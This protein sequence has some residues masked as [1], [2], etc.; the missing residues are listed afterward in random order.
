MGGRGVDPSHRVAVKGHPWWR[1]AA[2]Y[3]IYIRSFA[4]GDGD[5]LGDISGMRA[6]LGY[7]RDLGV[8]A[9]W[10]NPWYVSPMADAGYDVADYRDIDPSFGSLADALAFIEEAHDH[11]LRVIVDIVPNHCSSRHPWF[12]AALSAGPG[13]PQRA[14]FHFR[15]GTGSHGEL[16]PNNWKSSFGGPA[17]TRVTERDGTPGEWYLHL[18]APEQPDFNWDNPEVRSEFHEILRFWLDRGADGFRIDAADRLAKDPALPDLGGQVGVTPSPM[19]GYPAVHDIYRGWRQVVDG[20]PGDRVLVGE[21]WMDTEHRAVYHGPDELH[22]SFA[23]DLLCS[24]WNASAMRR[25]I[26]ANVDSGAATSAPATWVLGNHDVTRVVTRYGRKDTGFGPG[27]AAHGAAT[28]NSDHS[29][30]TRRARAAALLIMAL[31]GGVYIYQ[32]DELGLWEVEDIPAE[33]LQDPVWERSGHTDPGRDGCRVPL[34]WSGT[35]P[36]FGFSAGHPSARPWLPQPAGWR[37]LTAAAQ[38][39]DPGSM[40]SLYRA[41]LRLRRSEPGL[42]DGPM[43]WLESARDVLA[44]SRPGGFMCVVNF[45]HSPAV[46]PGHREVLLAS[47]PLDGGNLPPD[48][49][50]WLRT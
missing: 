36:P 48:T 19:R 37:N 11:G 39:A 3:Q 42:G 2:V 21:I 18:F 43:M 49:A 44:V 20:Y 15:P 27:G 50:A 34:P 24:P 35:A 32:G 30:G 23:L 13:S 41:A 8:D 9:V 1:D 10:V 25:V 46:L 12:L 14:R 33:Q 4:D 22:T 16:P 6:R 5:G 7:L 28:G 17:W 31:P 29:L 38:A 26:D 45:A 40:L 47:G